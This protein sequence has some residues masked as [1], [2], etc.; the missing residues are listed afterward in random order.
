MKRLQL[1]EDALPGVA[2]VAIVAN[3]SE[4]PP[5]YRALVSEVATQARARGLDA[6][7][8]EIGRRDVMPGVFAE[9][10]QT[11]SEAMLVLADTQV[12][13]PN[14]AE[15]VA[16]ATKHRLPAMYPWR[17]YTDIG[18]LMSYAT[19]I[20]HFNHRSATFVDRILR[21]AKPADLPVEQPTK[22]EFVVN[23]KTA[24]ALDLTIPSA[25]LLRADEVIE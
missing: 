2:R 4:R 13:E 5:R 24:R 10:E 3:P 18:G 14:R 19:S 7:V 8:F 12:L 1:L 6:R 22:F 11:R 15:V 23:V 25:V 9:M 20:P 17:F 21:G 16:L